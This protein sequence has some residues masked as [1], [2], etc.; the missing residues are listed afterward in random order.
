MLTA[1]IV[2]LL[3]TCN[4]TQ[5]L[6]QEDRENI[7]SYEEIR[8]LT[9]WEPLAFSGLGHSSYASD[10]SYGFVGEKNPVTRFGIFKIHR[11]GRLCFEFSRGRSG[12]CKMFLRG[13]EL[14][15]LLTEEGERFPFFLGMRGE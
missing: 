14:I 7:L 1:P 2:V 5:V 13:N 15:F 6:G 11:D 3:A 4:A 12:Q 8:D 10:G 9:S